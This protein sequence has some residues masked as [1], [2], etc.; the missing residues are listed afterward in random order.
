MKWKQAEVVPA[1]SDADVERHRVRYGRAKRCIG[2]L[3]LHARP[4]NKSGRRTCGTPAPTRGLLTPI[5]RE[6]AMV[7]ST[8]ANAARQ[9]PYEKI[10]EV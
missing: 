6:Q 1:E 8:A 5:S 9:P 4:P 7:Y 3:G 2:A 10:R